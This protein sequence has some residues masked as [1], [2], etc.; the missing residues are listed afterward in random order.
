MKSGE[1]AKDPTLLFTA[2]LADATNMGLAK[3]AESC[4]GTSLPKLSLLVARHIRDE[5]DSKALAE[6]VNYQHRV[7]F[8]THWGEGTTLSSDGQRYRAGGRGEAGG[9]VI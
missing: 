7:L 8:A 6:I 2:I 3:M 9:Q 4:P 5:P 1:P